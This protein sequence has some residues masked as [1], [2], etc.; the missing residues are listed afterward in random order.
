VRFY[1]STVRAVHIE[2]IAYTFEGT[3]MVGHLAHDEQPGPRP[4]VLLCHEGPGL[5]EHVKGRAERL[6]ELGYVAF[7]LDYHGGGV[8]LPLDEAMPKLGVL[9]GDPALVRRLGQA[10]LDVLLAQPGVKRDHVAVIGY[11]FGGAMAVELARTGADLKAVVG[12]HPSLGTSPDSKAIKGSVLICIGTDD[13]FVSL[14]QRLAFEKDM[15]D[16]KVS[17]WRFELYGDVGHSFTNPRADDFGMPGIAFDAKA[18]AR[19]WAAMLGL[20][21][22]TIAPGGAA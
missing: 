17:D 10:G 4:A 18:D 21:E 13:P 1:S 8:P 9:M 19:S 16:A 6:A 14:E 15:T 5:D 2:E 7:A 11:C 3:E 20:F 22:E 12:F